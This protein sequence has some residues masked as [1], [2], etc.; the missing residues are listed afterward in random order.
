MVAGN[1]GFSVAPWPGPEG[2][3]RAAIVREDAAFLTCG[4]KIEWDWRTFGDYLD[5]L[6]SR[7]PA[8]NVVAV[9]GHA[10]L[11]G[12]VMGRAAR[13]PD[14]REMARMCSLLEDA[15]QQ[16]AAGLSTGLIYYPSCYAR[17]EELVALARVVARHGK[18]YA[19][20]I[21]GE[22]ETLLAALGE[23]VR[24]ART[25]R[26]CT[27]VSN[28]KAESRP[29]WGKLEQALALLE[30]ARQE[31]IDIDCDQYPYTAYNT[32]L[33]SFLPPEVM[34]RD[35]R[36]L[37]SLRA[38]RQRLRQIMASG[39]PNWT[40]SIK[41]M[42][43]ND[44]VID[45]SGDGALDGRR[46]GELAEA[47]GKDPFDFLFDLLLEFGPHLRVIG[48]A[49]CEA[50]VELGLAQPEVMVGS[51]G[52]ALPLEGELGNGF[53]HPRSFGTFP[54]VL[55][56]YCREKRVLTLEEAIRKMTWLSA[57]KVGLYRRGAIREGWYAD[58]VLFDPTTVRDNATFERPRAQP[59]GV[60]SVWINGRRVVEEGKVLGITGTGRILC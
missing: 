8:V 54:R 4:M 1:C 49:M 57:R 12:Q 50:D 15:L 20:H 52:F 38:E 46:L 17:T 29:M 56:R 55:G 59:S 36:Q 48:H 9:V 26:V 33:G 42:E 53:P 31:G 10:A 22:G 40:S 41:G 5:V 27:Q 19:T 28:L 21:R 13:P 51:D 18:L 6:A 32:S 2:G 44:F 16:G 14:D 30:R 43:W 60:R 25:A 58:L 39:R 11:R 23:A 7:G 35:W 47:S 45:G 3:P 24:V 37:L 34:E